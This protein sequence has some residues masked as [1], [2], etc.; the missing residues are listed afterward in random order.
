MGGPSAGDVFGRAREIADDRSVIRFKKPCV[1][2]GQSLI[3]ETYFAAF[4]ANDGLVAQLVEQCPFKALVQ[5]SSPCQPT[6]PDPQQNPIKQASN[7]LHTWKIFK[8]NPFD[9]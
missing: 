6:N 1:W 7:A 3:C 8:E 2:M 9:P 4:S 5:G